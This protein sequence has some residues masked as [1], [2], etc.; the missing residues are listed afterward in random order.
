NK[1]YLEDQTKFAAAYAYFMGRDFEKSAVIFKTLQDNYDETI[2]KYANGYLGI[3]NLYEVIKDPCSRDEAYSLLREGPDEGIFAMYKGDAY[4]FFNGE[5]NNYMSKLEYRI[6]KAQEYY[7]MAYYNM[8]ASSLNY[9]MLD[10]RLTIMNNIIQR[11]SYRDYDYDYDY[12]YIFGIGHYRGQI[13]RTGNPNG[14]GIF[15]VTENG[16]ITYI[17]PGRYKNTSRSIVDLQSLS[18]DTS[19]DCAIAEYWINDKMQWSTFP[20][21]LNPVEFYYNLTSLNLHMDP[22]FFYEEW[23]S[24]IYSPR[25]AEQLSKK[26]ADYNK[27]YEADYEEDYNE[28]EYVD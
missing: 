23:D 3:M 13:D 5:T 24:P 6:T 8:A 11:K 12:N 28:D 9:Y 1:V 26:I 16:K 15:Y 18:F 27:G 19:R 22:D 10:A 2:A 20:G 4:L 7:N 14:W 17:K 25:K 21:S